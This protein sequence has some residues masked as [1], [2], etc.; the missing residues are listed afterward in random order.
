MSTELSRPA[1]AT[2]LGN[3][4]AKSVLVLLADQVNAEGFGW[5]SVDFIVKGTEINKR[6]VLRVIQVFMAMDLLAKVDRGAHRTPGLQLNLTLLGNDL[7][8]QF[9]H[10]YAEAQGTLKKACGKCLSDTGASVCETQQSVCE[11]PESVCETLPPHPLIGGPVK[12]PLR[13]QP[14]NPPQAGGGVLEMPKPELDEATDQVAEAMGIRKPR[15]WKRIRVVIE[16]E[17]R[18]TG[19]PPGEV[20]ADMIAAWKEQDRL[21]HLLFRRF[22]A[23]EMLELG[24]W[25]QKNQWHWDKQA[26][27]EKAQGSF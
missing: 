26:L 12:D 27:R 15:F 13:T 8:E 10:A 3:L 16:A 24:M 2:R 25:K 14:P 23:M 19:A 4:P 18:Q 21:G 7:R 20:A 6:T 17:C 1:Y 9:S 5:P 22:S 11:T